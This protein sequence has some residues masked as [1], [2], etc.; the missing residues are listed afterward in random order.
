MFCVCV[1]CVTTLL[2]VCLLVCVFV[3][4][5]C[6]FACLF[7]LVCLRVCVFL[8]CDVDLLWRSVGCFRAANVRNL[9]VG[10]FHFLCSVIGVVSV[11]VFLRLFSC[12]C[13]VVIHLLLH[14]H[15]ACAVWCVI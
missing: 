14:Y 3:L 10:A 1:V 6:M 7:G 5:V 11:T 15:V 8:Q 13:G 9:V 4:F 2:R 12:D